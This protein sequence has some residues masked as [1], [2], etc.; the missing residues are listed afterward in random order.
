MR[1][2]S[3]KNIRHQEASGWLG[4]AI[5]SLLALAMALGVTAATYSN[6]D[7]NFIPSQFLPG[8]EAK[9]TTGR[10]CSKLSILSFD[11]LAKSQR[12]ESSELFSHN[13]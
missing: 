1:E 2:Q 12:A 10:A 3:L 13:D 11:G 9:C 6:F 7:Y 8:D 5:S 4:F